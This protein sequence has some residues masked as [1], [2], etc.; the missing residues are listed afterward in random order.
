[1]SSSEPLVTDAN[2]DVRHWGSHLKKLGCALTDWM[3]TDNDG[4]V[5]TVT[6][7]SSLPVI[8]YWVL[9]LVPSNQITN[10]PR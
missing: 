10:Q 4:K 1:M 3:R 8:F 2:R 9:I 7:C 5:S 6:V